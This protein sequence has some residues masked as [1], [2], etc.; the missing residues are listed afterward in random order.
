MKFIPL[1]IGKIFRRTRM[2]FE[3]TGKEIQLTE[4]GFIS[5]DEKLNVYD[6]S[7]HIGKPEDFTKKER[8]ELA[9]TIIEQWNKFKDYE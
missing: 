5:I 6:C 9:D 3:S 7:Y 2:I 8:K 4:K 1:K